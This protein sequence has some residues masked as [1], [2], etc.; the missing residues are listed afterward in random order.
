ME[1]KALL[2]NRYK[3]MIRSFLQIVQ[4]DSVTVAQYFGQGARN[5]TLKVFLLFWFVLLFSLCF[6]N[7][8]HDIPATLRFHSQSQPLSHTGDTHRLHSEASCWI[9]IEVIEFLPVTRH[10]SFSMDSSESIE[11]SASE[12]TRHRRGSGFVYLLNNRVET[13]QTRP[14]IGDWAESNRGISRKTETSNSQFWQK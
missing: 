12:S 9:P 5:T 6:M 8:T 11:T 10:P 3:C 4:M 1:A 13:N 2:T 7:R 14:Q